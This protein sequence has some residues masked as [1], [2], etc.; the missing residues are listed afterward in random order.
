MFFKR[1]TLFRFFG[2]DVRADAS[3]LFMSVFISW[4][5]ASRL[6]PVLL[7]GMDA[8]TYQFMGIFTL[9]GLLFSIIAHEVAHAVIA[10]Y[11]DMPI[12]AITLF[13][14][15]GVAEM[16]GE[17]SHPKGEFFM[18]IAGPVMSFLLALFFWALAHLMAPVGWPPLV[19]SLN[20][21]GDLNLYIAIFNLAPAFPLDGGRALRAIIW[22]RRRNL[23]QATRI[24]GELGAV[25]AYALMAWACYR[26]VWHD[27]LVTGIWMTLLGLFVFASGARAVRDI[28]S[29]AVLSHEKV[30]RFMHSK[31]TTVPPHL[32]IAEVVERYALEHYQSD[33]PV[34]EDGRLT[35]VL[36]LQSILQLDRGKWPWLHVAS[37][38]TPINHKNCVT[39]DVSA[40]DALELLARYY[41]SQLMVA[42]G[43]RLLGAVEYRDLAAYLNVTMKIDNN[44]P[45]E[46][47]R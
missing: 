41:Q 10:E 12:R 36:T 1:V 14:F 32:T 25:L 3:W 40:A 6:Y 2:F 46:K 47:S 34:V 21:L 43:D 30:R 11:Y 20:Y 44:V 15:G 35:G 8:D 19:V 9:A 27:D 4:T 18:A 16:R 23:V 22:H 45:V 38:M 13:I 7:P 39:P 28:E 26:L 24:A 17:P 42:D 29:R 37:V 5:L 33:Y 31:L